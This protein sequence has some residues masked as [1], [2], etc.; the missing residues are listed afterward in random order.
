MNAEIQ[1]TI[2]EA[3]VP[4]DHPIIMAHVGERR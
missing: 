2:N 3:Y 1:R 4:N